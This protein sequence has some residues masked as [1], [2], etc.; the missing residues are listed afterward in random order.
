MGRGSS[1]AIAAIA[2][3]IGNGWLTYRKDGKRIRR[4]D[5]PEL[6]DTNGLTIEQIAARAEANGYQV[7]RYNKKQLAQHD[8]ERREERAN[9]PDYELGVG[10][11]WGNK[12]YRKRARQNRINTRQARKR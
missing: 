3:N 6:V 5:E 9:R 7:V 12:E 8:R 10:V 4:L 2:V 11:S 1:G